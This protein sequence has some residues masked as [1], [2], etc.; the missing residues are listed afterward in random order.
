[1]AGRKRAFADATLDRL[2]LA[3]LQD[4]YGRAA[5]HAAN[6]DADEAE[7]YNAAMEVVN[8]PSLSLNDKRSILMNWAWNEYLID[9]AVGEGMPDNGRPSRLREVELA[10]LALENSAT[11]KSA[12]AAPVAA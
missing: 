9:Q 5:V 12:N 6:S 7:T 2:G 11:S 8:D 4:N 3:A 1:V 10:L